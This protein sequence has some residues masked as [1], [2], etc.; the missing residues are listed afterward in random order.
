MLILGEGDAQRQIMGAADVLVAIRAL[1][2]ENL[3]PEFDDAAQRSARTQNAA[4]W[5]FRVIRRFPP[6]ILIVARKDFINQL[7]V[8]FEIG[9]ESGAVCRLQFCESHAVNSLLGHLPLR[10]TWHRA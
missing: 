4:S 10:L 2:P 8:V 5:V 6:A 3:K 1:T 9:M 7:H